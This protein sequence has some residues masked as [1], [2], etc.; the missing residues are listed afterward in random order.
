MNKY[1]SE[2]LFNANNQTDSLENLTTFLKF[3]Y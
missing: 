1:F 2:H 3:T